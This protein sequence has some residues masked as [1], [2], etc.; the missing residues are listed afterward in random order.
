MTFYLFYYTMIMVI[1]SPEP[2][3]CVKTYIN[4]FF[5]LSYLRSTV[6]LHYTNHIA[7]YCDS[8]IQCLN[9]KRQKHNENK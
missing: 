9:M 6:A 2:E 4:M 3:K 7:T 8:T 5:L 1:N